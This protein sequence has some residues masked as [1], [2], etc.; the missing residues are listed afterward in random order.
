MDSK[1]SSMD[2]RKSLWK[3][4]MSR[5][6]IGVRRLVSNNPTEEITMSMTG[7]QSSEAEGMGDDRKSTSGGEIECISSLISSRGGRKE[8]Q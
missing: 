8:D 4:H 2:R 3:E 6:M 7:S 5:V 1:R